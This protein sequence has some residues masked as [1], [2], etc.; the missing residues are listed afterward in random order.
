MVVSESSSQGDCAAVCLNT[1]NSTAY[2]YVYDPSHHYY[3][4]CTLYSGAVTKG[5]AQSTTIC[6]V[7]GG[8]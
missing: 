3:S 8:K 4:N 2:G 1:V 6:G 5:T 7:V